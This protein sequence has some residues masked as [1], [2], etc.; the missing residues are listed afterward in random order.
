M[1]S[2]NAFG[3]N[4]VNL[5]ILVFL[6]IESAIVVRKKLHTMLSL[7]PELFY[8]DRIEDKLENNLYSDNQISVD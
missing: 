4:F 5:R 2:K 1:V 3:G 7:F 8:A 6:P